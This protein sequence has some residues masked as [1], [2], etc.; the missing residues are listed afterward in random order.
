[1][2]IPFIPHITIGNSKDPQVCATLA[3]RLNVENFAI[4]GRISS[5]DIITHENTRI[6]T[7]CQV[8]L[9]DK[10]NVDTT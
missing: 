5:I 1:M 10:R 6:E 7:I 2:D 9:V 4:A 3:D 8:E